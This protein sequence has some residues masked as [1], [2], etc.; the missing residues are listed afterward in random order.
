M[1]D[2]KKGILKLGT[3]DVQ[4]KNNL[5]KIPLYSSRFLSIHGWLS[6]ANWIFLDYY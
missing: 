1:R 3:L 2:K 4:T 5:L 6:V